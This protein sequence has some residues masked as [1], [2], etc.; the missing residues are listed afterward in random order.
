[1][2]SRIH[3]KNIR[4]NKASRFYIFARF[5]LSIR[6][7]I[8][9]QSHPVSPSPFTRECWYLI[10]VDSKVFNACW[11]VRYEFNATLSINVL[12]STYAIVLALLFKFSNAI[13]FNNRSSYVRNSS[14]RTFSS[15]FF[16]IWRKKRNKIIE[17]MYSQRNE[18]LLSD[19]TSQSVS[20]D[21]MNEPGRR[22]GHGGRK[23][24]CVSR[25]T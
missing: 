24:R 6:R 22:Q 23:G 10:F 2:I 21:V 9:N 15:P 14:K 16:E 12:S 4:E 17:R 5:H 8:Y 19:L 20:S 11:T 25:S 13:R 18:R 7:P 3:Y 1:M